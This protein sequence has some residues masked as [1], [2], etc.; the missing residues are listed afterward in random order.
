MKNK[1][2]FC[3]L[4]YSSIVYSQSYCISK[5]SSP[6]QEWIA[7]VQF[8]TINHFSTKEGYGDFTNQVANVQRGLS[9]ALRV[10]QGFSWASDP[11]N[12]TQQ[13]RVWMDFNQN[14]SFEASELVATLSRNATTA[15]IPIPENASF[16]N[17]RMRISLKTNGIPTPCEIFDKGEVEDY[18]INVVNI[19]QNLPDLTLANLNLTNASVAQGQ[20]LYYKFDLKNVGTGDA[21]GNFN[22]KS[23]ISSDNILSLDDM[24]DGI[25]PTA[26]FPAGFSALQ[27]TGAST[28]RSPLA[29]GQYYLI[30]VADA[31]NQIIENNENNNILLSLP[32]RVTPLNET[33]CLNRFDLGGFELSGCVKTYPAPFDYRGTL[34]QYGSHIENGFQVT[35][36]SSIL[37]S[38]F[39]ANF[40]ARNGVGTPQIGSKYRNCPANWVYFTAT[41]AKTLFFK[42][43]VETG[44][45][46]K[47]YLRVRTFG[48][49][50]RPDSLHLELDSTTNQFSPV[51]FWATTNRSQTCNPCFATDQTLP[52]ITGCPSVP[53]VDFPISN[54]APFLTGSMIKQF[55]GVQITD[56]CNILNDV[57]QYVIPNNFTGIW[58]T[59]QPVKILQFDSAGNKAVC[60]T[61]LRFVPNNRP[62]TYCDSKGTA[63]WEHWM[64]RVMVEGSAPTTAF[65]TTAKE[66]YGN[67]TALPPAQMWRNGTAQVVLKPQ[68]SWLGNPL[69]TNMLWRVW[70]DWNNDNSFNGTDEQVISRS[71][72]I[73]NGA[74]L[75]NEAAFTVPATAFLGNTRMRIAMKVGAYPS[76]CET[77]EKGEVEDY[78]VNVTNGGSLARVNNAINRSNTISYGANIFPNPAAQEAF[79]DLKAFE[80]ERVDIGISDVAGKLL[81]KQTIEKA[82]VSPHRLD[83]SQL[84]NGAYL[85]QIQSIAKR[86]ETCTLYILN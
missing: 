8:G 63:P 54:P 22:V 7:N 21:Y 24:Q 30:L 67:F 6:W 66:G 53:I 84:K 61:K 1:I 59:I 85:I 35:F 31:D 32:F 42:R 71:V 19:T 5:G 36:R 72:S 79:L 68:S 23:Y 77:F 56:N 45:E 46:S 34:Q 75:D 25:V 37:F 9:Y 13:G 62:P 86:T 80:N 64:E 55:L 33:I 81:W 17:M 74:F 60:E 49:A 18:T 50:L 52:T 41:G 47:L 44:E 39:E 73:S 12:G 69:N 16:G 14:G 83:V 15:N 10:T 65:P 48:D 38:S 78:T 4:L 11:A 20:I 27:V 70:V 58:G 43:S 57:F 28:I 51:H 82:I 29:A 40:Y 2:L 76:P 3:A 26:N